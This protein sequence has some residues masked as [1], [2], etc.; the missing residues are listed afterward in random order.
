[1]KGCR[2]LTLEEV[3][4]VEAALSPRNRSLFVLGI[5]TGLRISE[6]LSLRVRDV[7]ERAI[8]HRRN[9]KGRV[10]GRQIYLNAKAREAVAPLLNQSPYARLFPISRTQA[11]RILDAAFKTVGLTGSTGTHCMRKTYAERMYTLLGGDLI[12]MQ[13]A[14]GHKWVTS[15]A[16]YLSFKDEDI[17]EAMDM[18]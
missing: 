3:E 6:L 11:W 7:G 14:L 8:V 18:L 12:K 2:P 9:V 17:T 1:M 15:T 16:A 5:N 4:K 13:A 10:E